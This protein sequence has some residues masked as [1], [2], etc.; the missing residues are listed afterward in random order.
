MKDFL[1][2]KQASEELSKEVN[3]KGYEAENELRNKSL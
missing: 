2:E 1:V 3:K